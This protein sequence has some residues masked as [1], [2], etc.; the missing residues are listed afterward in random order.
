MSVKLKCSDLCYLDFFT[1]V[2]TVIVLSVVM[3]KYSHAE[4]QYSECRRIDSRGKKQFVHAGN[5]YWREGYVQL[6]SLSY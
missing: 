2:L 1:V 4:C 5:T 3:E 6:T